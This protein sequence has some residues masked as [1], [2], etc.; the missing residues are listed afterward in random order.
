MGSIIKPTKNLIK[1]LKS[2]KETVDLSTERFLCPIELLPLAALISE[3]S[4]KFIG[5]ASSECAG[6]M[7]F[8]NF[9]NGLMRFSAGSRKFIPIY[10]FSA[11]KAD[12]KSLEDKSGILKNLIGICLHKIESPKGAINALNIAIDEIISNVEDHSGAK[13]GWINAQ[14]YPNKKFLDVCILDRGI[15]ITG[16][17]RAVGKVFKS[18]L[19][20]LKNALE[21]YSSKPERVRGSG[22]PT[23]IKMITQGFEGEIIA[24]S[25]SAIAYASKRQEPVVQKLSVRWDGTIIAFRIPKNLKPIDYSLYIDQ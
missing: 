25:G 8:F 1:L 18:D 11:S 6:Y 22:L 24:I 23:F 9:P 10:K 19:D 21:G 17:Y 13:Y 3:K 15:T 14:Y 12:R 20:A 4:L 2:A 7:E 5:P 16:R